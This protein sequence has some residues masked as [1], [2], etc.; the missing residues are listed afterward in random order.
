MRALGVKVGHSP[1]P[2]P[3]PAEDCRRRLSAYQHNMAGDLLSRLH[4]LR[5]IAN[6]Q[7][8]QLSDLPSGLVTRFVGQD[9]KKFLLHIYSNADIWDMEAM[10]QFVHE[11][12]S[13]DPRA[14][15]NPLQTYEASRQMKR[16]YEQA[17]WYALAELARSRRGD[18]V[19]VH[20]AAG[21][22]GSALVRLAKLAGCRVVAVVGG[23][24]KV[25]PT[26]TG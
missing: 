22:V 15:G 10:E 2:S 16:S 11:V 24:H 17:A 8:P 23:S 3:M 9:G 1:R 18:T 7:P 19:L 13:V 25:D 5:S 14:T 4:T 12:R 26:R 20:S 6:P 21:G